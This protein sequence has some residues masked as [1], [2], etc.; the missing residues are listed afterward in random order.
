MISRHCSS[1]MPEGQPICPSCYASVNLERREA[2]ERPKTNV[3]VFISDTVQNN[4]FFNRISKY[5]QPD[6]VGWAWAAETS[7]QFTNI[8]KNPS[9]TCGLLIVGADLF[10]QQAVLL[11]DFFSTNPQVLVAVQYDRK[12]TV[13]ASPP[14]AGAVLF[15]HPSDIDEWLHLVHQLLNLSEDK[16]V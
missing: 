3:L 14:I 2:P 9:G 10:S 4:V 5:L 7:E 13:P 6:R 8:T 16:Q 11:N 12:E 15:V 1:E